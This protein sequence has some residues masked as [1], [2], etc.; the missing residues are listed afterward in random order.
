MQIL[1]AS[2]TFALTLTLFSQLSRA[3]TVLDSE[4]VFSEALGREM[5]VSIYL[6]DGHGQGDARYPVLYLLHGYG[7]NQLEWLTAGHAE[8]VVDQLIDH[9]TIPPVIVVMPD[10]QNSWYVDSA[11]FGGP[12]DYETAMIRDLVPEIDRRYRTRTDASGRMIA[13]VSMG[14]FGALRL[15]LKYPDQFSAIGA[16]SPAI[17][18]DQGSSWR[19]SPVYFD[20][21]TRLALFGQTMGRNFDAS[22]YIDRSPF[23]ELAH[24]LARNPILRFWLGVGDDD[25]FNLQD[26]TLDLYMRLRT[27]GLSPELR[28]SDGPHQWVLY[29]RLIP[30]LL[31][32]LTA[33]LAHPAPE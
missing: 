18:D 15:G 2:V 5:A 14:G 21:E 29:N 26:G 11:E 13:G 1:V 28:V 32:F 9:G 23:S 12:G 7:G 33:H 16:L 10:A 4:T 8:V 22:V 3:G 6:P 31:A 27:L 25:D 20:R 24:G 19:H 30:D 17:F